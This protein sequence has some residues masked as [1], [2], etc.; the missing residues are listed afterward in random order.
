MAS[1]S[2]LQQLDLIKLAVLCQKVVDD[3]GIDEATWKQ[4]AALKQEWVLLVGCE[5][6]SARDFKTHE[7]IQAAKADLKNR[8]VELLT[9]I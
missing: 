8:M 9:L 4:A 5:T 2:D 7:Q 6:P 1:K 3:T